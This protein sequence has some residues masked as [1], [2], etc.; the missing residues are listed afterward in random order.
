MKRVAFLTLD[1]PSDYVIDDH[2][3]VPVMAEAGWRVD[4]VS[5]RAEVDWN[6][7][8]A[9]LIRTPWDYQDDP[10]AFLEVLATIEASSARLENSIETVR[11][12]LR[13][14]YLRDLETRGVL[15]VPTIWGLD[16]S[17]SVEG[18]LAALEAKDFGAEFES[19]NRG[20]VVKPVVSANAY[21]TFPI[22]EATSR[23][24]LESIAGTF[25]RADG[26]VRPYM[27][28]PFVRSVVEEGEV[29]L[30]YFGREFS[31]AVLK[32]PKS[33]DFRVQ[34]EHGGAITVLEEEDPRFTAMARRRIGERGADV[35]ASLDPAPLYARVDLVRTAA[36]D[37]AAMEVELIEPSLYFR[38]HPDAPG[39][40]VSAFDRWMR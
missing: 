10:D 30:F 37:F 39:N 20:I 36:D 40:F 32:T 15:I 11:W 8:D 21:D 31:H 38:M 17:P 19:G 33:G 35:M 25:R 26:S 2:L 18:L 4:S 22:T 7:W 24:E 3:V 1:D 6:D 12:N 34:E 23:D 16:E 9:V 5:W 13:K 28:Q 29:S 14:T 27:I